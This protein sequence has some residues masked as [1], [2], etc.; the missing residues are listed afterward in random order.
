MTAA[1]C[2]IAATVIESGPDRFALMFVALAGIAA[3]AN[4]IAAIQVWRDSVEGLAFSMVLQ[5]VNIY[6]C[7]LALAFIPLKSSLMDTRAAPWALLLCMVGGVSSLIPLYGWRHEIANQ[8]AYD[9][10]RRRGLVLLLGLFLASVAI[11]LWST[12]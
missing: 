9:R 8:A 3:A 2:T 6:G 10:G 7:L 12:A 4:A 5:M 1:Y 11:A